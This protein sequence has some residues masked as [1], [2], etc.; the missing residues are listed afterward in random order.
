M[1]AVGGVGPLAG[2]A[3]TVEADEERAAAGAVDV[4]GDPVAALLPAV[5]Q[6]TAADVLGAGAERRGDG[7]G[8]HGQAL[9]CTLSGETLSGWN[10]AG[11]TLT[12]R[13][14]SGGKVRNG[15]R[16]MAGL[17][18]GNGTPDIG[19]PPPP[20]G[21]GAR[22]RGPDGAGSGPAAKEKGRRAKRRPRS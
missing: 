19:R 12:G 13:T 4:A 1:R 18:H 16:G 2:R 10:P 9:S 21:A 15:S 17:L 3:G 8:I 5:R 22:M 11:L 7:G 6:V 14:L 20:A